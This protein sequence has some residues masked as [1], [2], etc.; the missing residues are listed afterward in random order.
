MTTK[1]QRQ[2]WN[3]VKAEIIRR[4][5]TIKR[6]GHVIDASSEAIRLTAHGKCPKVASRLKAALS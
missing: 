3:Q 1:D 4:F 5:G 6:C 2:S